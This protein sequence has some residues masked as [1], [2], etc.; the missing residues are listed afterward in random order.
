LFNPEAI[1]NDFF[2]Y[3]GIR[4]NSKLFNDVVSDRVSYK[5]TEDGL[6]ISFLVPGYSKNDLNL[7]LQENVLIVESNKEKQSQEKLS[8]SF[9]LSENI[10]ADSITSK[11]ENGIL[12][13]VA[14]FV[15]PESKRRIIKI[16]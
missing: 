13:V 3:P 4:S 15:K 16:E 2:A 12:T 8:M 10:D 14:K 5:T 11:C 1:L 9:V 7:S 6:V